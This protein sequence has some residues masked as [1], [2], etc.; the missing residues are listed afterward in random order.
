[1]DPENPV[2]KLCLEGMKMEAVGNSEAARRLF[3]QAWSEATDD[4]QACIAAHYLARQQE[5]DDETFHWNQEALRRAEAA[6]D[7]R[8]ESFYPSLYLNMWKSHEEAG[9][10]EEARRYYELA[11]ERLGEVPE[12]EYGDVVREGVARALKR[13]GRGIS[14]IAECNWV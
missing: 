9:D 1:M 4:Y 8:V 11:A 2:V 14:S 10:L 5:S 6:N 12:G 3:E 7:E 13:I